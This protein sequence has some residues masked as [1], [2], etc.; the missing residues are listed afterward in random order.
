MQAGYIFDQRMDQLMMPNPYLAKSLVINKITNYNIL[1][2]AMVTAVAYSQRI[3][4]KPPSSI[5]NGSKW[6]QK[7]T[8]PF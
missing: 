8:K 5:H 4:L 3:L 6:P 2:K 1:Q 7:M